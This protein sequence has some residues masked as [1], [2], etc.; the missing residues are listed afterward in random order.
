MY[1][2]SDGAVPAVPR[3]VTVAPA[4]LCIPDRKQL[5]GSANK[6]NNLIKQFSSIEKRTLQN[7]LF[8]NEPFPFFIEF[9]FGRIRTKFSHVENTMNNRASVRRNIIFSATIEAKRM[10]KTDKL[11]LKFG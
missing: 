6:T 2:P 7:P 1:G 3:R 10:K 9:H 11:L 5:G 8:E 4:P